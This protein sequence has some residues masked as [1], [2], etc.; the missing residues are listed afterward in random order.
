VHAAPWSVAQ[1]GH[2]DASHGFLNVN[3]ENAIWFYNT[4]GPGDIVEV[5]NTGIALDPTDGL[6]DWILSW[7]EW[8]AGSALPPSPPPSAR[9]VN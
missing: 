4:F 2:Q 9:L 5:R 7:Q 1:Q 3:P 8:L 6:G